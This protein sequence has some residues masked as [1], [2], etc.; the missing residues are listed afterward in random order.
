MSVMKKKDVVSLIRY[1]IENNDHAFREVAY[2]IADGFMQ[3]GDEQIGSYIYGLLSERNNFIPQKVE[4]ESEFLTKVDVGGNSLPLPIPIY[5][6]IIGI[7]NAVGYDSGMN[8]FLFSGSPGTGKTESAKQLARILD[9]ELYSVNMESL[10]D[11]RLGQTAKNISTVFDEINS[12]HAPERVV[13]LFDEIDALALN[14]TDKHDMRE[15]GRATSAVLKGFDAL[16]PSV[17]VVATTNLLKYFDMALLRRFD[18]IVD[19]DRYTREDLIEIA[20]AILNEVLEKFRFAGRNKRLFNKI[21]S[22]CQVIPY[23]GVLKNIIRSSVAFSNP[24]DAYDYFRRLFKNLLPDF[25]MD[26]KALKDAGFTLREIEILSS[27]SKS[28]ASRLLRLDGEDR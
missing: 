13:I 25:P 9:R 10:V 14:R 19:F 8:K 17:V 11:S 26:V 21:L 23:P 6:D 12:I 4:V 5:D 7:V 18:T 24:A 16:V 1:H 27:V 20:N 28:T 2:S 15:M 22:L 3:T